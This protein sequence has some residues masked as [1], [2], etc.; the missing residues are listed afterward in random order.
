MCWALVD[1]VPVT[2][3]ARHTN[4]KEE[5]NNRPKG[6][7][8]KATSYTETLASWAL[9]KCTNVT[10]ACCESHLYISQAARLLR[11]FYYHQ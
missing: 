3:Q 6:V 8:C 1:S 9:P 5:G 11:F 2:V 7:T 10:S 4:R